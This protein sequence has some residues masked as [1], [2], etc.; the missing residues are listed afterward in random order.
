MKISARMREDMAVYRPCDNGVH[1]CGVDEVKERFYTEA[2]FPCVGEPAARALFG[3][4][5]AEFAASDEEWDL[6]VDLTIAD[7]MIVEDFGISRQMLERF[8]SSADQGAASQGVE[9]LRAEAALAAQGE[10]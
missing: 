7:G 6:T 9:P 1:V 2:N 5:K 3:R 10:V 8:R 4:L